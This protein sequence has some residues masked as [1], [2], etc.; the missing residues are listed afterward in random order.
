MALKA[1][2]LLSQVTFD[3]PYPDPQKKKEIV[4]FAP[5]FTELFKREL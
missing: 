5:A 2:L 4:G 1:S 3:I